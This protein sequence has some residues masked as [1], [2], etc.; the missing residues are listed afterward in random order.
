[1]SLYHATVNWRYDVN[2]DSRA[3]SH[4]SSKTIIQLIIYVSIESLTLWHGLLTPEDCCK[5]TH[6]DMIYERS[7]KV[8]G[9]IILNILNSNIN[10]SVSFE[11]LNLSA[12]SL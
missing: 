5:Q 2:G 8:S 1:M 12:V 6:L 7:L 4:N 9:W 11:Y 3:Y 10:F